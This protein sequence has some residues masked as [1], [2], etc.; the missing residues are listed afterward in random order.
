MCV[1]Q[2]GLP[3]L[4]EVVL[5]KQ[6]GRGGYFYLFFYLF[7]PGGHA[8]A[9]PAETPNLDLR[10]RTTS[11]TSPRAQE[12]RQEWVPVLPQRCPGSRE[13]HVPK[14]KPRALFEGNEEFSFSP[15]Q[16]S[17]FSVPVLSKAHKDWGPAERWPDNGFWYLLFRG[18]SNKLHGTNISEIALSELWQSRFVTRWRHFC[19]SVR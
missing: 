7:W 3:Y 4:T 18:N 14:P 5:V 19:C 15:L 13:M 16:R 11:D 2:T 12:G 10:M 8:S 17:T 9:V 1:A 6:Q